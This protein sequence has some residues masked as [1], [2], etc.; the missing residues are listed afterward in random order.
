MGGA[1]EVEGGEGGALGGRETQSNQ[2]VHES[3]TYVT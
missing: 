2:L 1:G 3:L